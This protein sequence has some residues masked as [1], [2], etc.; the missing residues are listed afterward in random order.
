MFLNSVKND[1]FAPETVNAAASDDTNF[2]FVLDVTALVVVW[3]ISVVLIKIVAATSNLT[4]VL[5][6]HFGLTP[7][8]LIKY[9]SE[10]PGAS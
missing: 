3:R 4:D 8:Y 7:L 1:I 2:M 10:R 5:G 6:S 9:S